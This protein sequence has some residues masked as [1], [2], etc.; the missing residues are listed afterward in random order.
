MKERIRNIMQH[1]RLSQQEF[2]ARLGISA[3]SLSSIF[4]G[5]TNPTNNHV[6]AVHRAFPQINVNWLLFGE[7]D[8][9]DHS[10]GDADAPS[11]D[12]APAAEGAPAATLPTASTGKN[13]AAA[14]AAGPRPTPSSPAAP[15]PVAA[16]E[17]PAVAPV[18][19]RRQVKEIRVFYDDGTYE[20]FS[21]LKV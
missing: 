14:A 8:M 1:E 13:G 18:V 9:M 10:E 19:L 4:T 7:G 5:R 12:A 2:A 6:M 11:P 16:A 3:A 21:P 17:M 15:I 20:S